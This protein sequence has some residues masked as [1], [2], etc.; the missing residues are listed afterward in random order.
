MGHNSGNLRAVALARCAEVGIQSGALLRRDLDRLLVVL[1]GATLQLAD[2]EPPPEKD[3]R[4]LGEEAGFLL[5]RIAE[6]GM[7][8]FTFQDKT[9]GDWFVRPA[10]VL[11]SL[12]AKLE[13]V[14]A[15]VTGPA[16]QEHSLAG[17]SLAAWCLVNYTFQRS[18][19][20]ANPKGK[21]SAQGGNWLGMQA[22][23]RLQL[24]DEAKRLA[25]G[26]A[27]RP[28]WMP[29]VDDDRDNKERLNKF[30]DGLQVL[31]AAQPEPGNVA[32]QLEPENLEL[33]D[34]DHWIIGADV[35]GEPAAAH[36]RGYT[37]TAKNGVATVCSTTERPSREAF[38]GQ[39]LAADHYRGTTVTFRGKV[40]AEG[41]TGH[42]ELGL[43]IF[44]CDHSQ[45]VRKVSPVI[46]GDQ[47]CKRHEVTAQVPDEAEFIQFSLT[48]TGTGR[49]ALSNVVLT[50]TQW[51]RPAF[52]SG[53]ADAAG[54]R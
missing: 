16:G 6:I 23:T 18:K 30:I 8:A 25:T 52:L 45:S 15:Q 44:P 9:Y 29:L 1:G 28:S 51:R 46:S 21:I 20:G 5:D 48:L 7:Y 10:L 34:L 2:L 22:R 37:A 24:W 13:K 32:V 19:E 11:A 50:S 33:A 54:H 31:V 3:H 38:L 12:E 4:I 17:R 35:H 26:P 43:H 27:M 49:V 47:D 41:V 36:P 42:A 53:P 40:Q 39:V 14:D